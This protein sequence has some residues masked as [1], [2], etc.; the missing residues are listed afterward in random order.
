M[1][2]PEK[3]MS[4]E[5]AAPGT[6]MAPI[7]LFWVESLARRCLSDERQEL[8]RLHDAFSFTRARSSYIGF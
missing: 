8:A 2:L 4:E 6:N 7:E 3:E 5:P 1:H